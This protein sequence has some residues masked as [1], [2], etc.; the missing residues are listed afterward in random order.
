[1]TRDALRDDRWFALLFMTRMLGAAVAVLILAA[2]RVTHADGTLI[3]ATLGWTALTL[4]AFGR[5][6][7][8]RAAPAAWLVDTGGAVALVLLSGDWRSPFYVYALTTLILP[9]TTLPWRLAVGWSAAFSLAYFGTAVGTGHLPLDTIGNT[10]RL[11]TLATH[12]FVPLI[13]G[14]AL[15]YAGA[16]LARLHRERERAERLAIQTERQR[17]AWELHDS[18]KQRVHAAHLLL[19]AL[20]GRLHGTDHGVAAQALVELRG[21]TADMETSIAELRTPVDGRSVDDLLRERAAELTLTGTARLTVVGRLPPLPPLVAAHAYRIAAEALTNAIRHARCTA[22]TVVL[23]GRADGARLVVEDDGV[24]IHT[25]RRPQ[26]HGLRSMRARAE[27]IGG[28]LDIGP[29]RDG[30]GTRVALLLSD[31]PD[32]TEPAP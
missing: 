26:G 10:I 29:G 1:M 16:L 25:A 32:T 27:T 18:A 20:D 19:S 17:I 30:R 22:V 13:V 8:I 21:A 6:E 5:S 9:A 28:R 24:G 15:A 4:A 31:H 7:R 3:A 2:H 23:D 14:L 12:M 11:E